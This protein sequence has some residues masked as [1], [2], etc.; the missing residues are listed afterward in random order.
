LKKAITNS[1]TINWNSRAG[2]HTCDDNGRIEGDE[3]HKAVRPRE[4][5]VKPALKI[6]TVQLDITSRR[7]Q[8]TLLLKS[9]ALATGAALLMMPG[10]ATTA[11]ANSPEAA[12]A[13]PQTSL[14]EPS[15]LV[16]NQKA[17]GKSVMIHYT[18]MPKAGYVAIY[19]SGADG[20]PTG[21]PLGSIHLPAG[22]HRDIKVDLK[23]EVPAKTQLWAAMYEDKDGD[24]KLDKSKDQ[25]FWAGQKLPWENK[26]QIE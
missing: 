8:M 12:K 5:A 18:L 6:T 25:A 13:A 2:A 24:T 19:G 16:F 26:F 4:S 21:D 11:I 23:S 17:D 14:T 22:D 7:K 20:K 15:V 9:S 3:K 10:L 1:S